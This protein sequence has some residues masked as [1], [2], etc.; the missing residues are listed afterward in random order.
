MFHSNR[1]RVEVVERRTIW[2]DFSHMF[3]L[4]GESRVGIW[5]DWGQVVF[6]PSLFLV[7]CGSNHSEY[8]V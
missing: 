8:R 6:L 7:A 1:K 4:D 2:V 5:A 3:L